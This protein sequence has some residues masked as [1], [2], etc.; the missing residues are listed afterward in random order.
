MAENHI[1]IGGAKYFYCFKKDNKEIEGREIKIGDK[2]RTV[3]ACRLRPDRTAY[4][5]TVIETGKKWRDYDAVI[6]EGPDGSKHQFLT[7]NLR[8]VEA[9]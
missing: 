7:K 5:L 9:V 4:T 1:K 3:K 8:P 2:V 6:C